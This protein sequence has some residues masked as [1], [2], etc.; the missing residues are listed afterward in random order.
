MTI[1]ALAALGE[2]LESDLSPHFGR[3][4]YYV[5]VDIKDN[6]VTDV[7]VKHSPF[8]DGHGPG[9]VP[10][11][12]ARSGANVIIA[13]GMGMRAI[14]WFQKLGVNPVTTQPRKINDIVNDYIAGKLEG[15]E[16]CAESEAHART[17]HVH[18]H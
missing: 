12:I 11:F 17:G 4:P 15:A 5:F 6:K 1:L 3:C 8:F 13:G 16:S 2:D 10:Q 18:H 9:D 7:W 14:D